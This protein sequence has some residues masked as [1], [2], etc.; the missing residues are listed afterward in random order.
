MIEETAAFP[1]IDLYLKKNW[2]GAKKKAE[3]MAITTS[4]SNKIRKVQTVLQHSELPRGCW[5]EEKEEQDPKCSR[6]GK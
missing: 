3:M 5:K 4:L 2:K 6:K 1:G